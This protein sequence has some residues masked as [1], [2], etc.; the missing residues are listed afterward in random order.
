MNRPLELLG[1][2]SALAITALID[3]GDVTI[4]FSVSRDGRVSLAVYDA[5]W[6]MV[7]TLL[8]GAP[9]KGRTH[10]GSSRT[11]TAYEIY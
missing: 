7:R 1:I 4:P 8:T 5:Q 11:G 10:R 6:R 2:L 3:A 9:R